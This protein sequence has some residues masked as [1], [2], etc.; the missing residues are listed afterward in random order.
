MG[1]DAGQGSEEGRVSGVLQRGTRELGALRRL[2]LSSQEVKEKSK[3]GGGERFVANGT[4]MFPT[5]VFFPFHRTLVNLI[6]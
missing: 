5:W 2:S 6:L 1:P 3:R 4:Q